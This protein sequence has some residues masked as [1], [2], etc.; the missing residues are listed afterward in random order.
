MEEAEE[1]VQ[2]FKD[3]VLPFGEQLSFDELWKRTLS[4]K[5]RSLGVSTSETAL[6]EGWFSADGR[7]RPM[8]SAAI[9]S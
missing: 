8:L 9:A 4:D 3:G 2:S 6:P 7:I 1:L 5:L